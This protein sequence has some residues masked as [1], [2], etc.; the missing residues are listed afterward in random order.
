MCALLGSS[1]RT[2]AGENWTAEVSLQSPPLLKFQHPL[3]KLSVERV[4]LPSQ[5]IDIDEKKD[6]SLAFARGSVKF[7]N[8]VDITDRKNVVV[9]YQSSHGEKTNTMHN[10]LAS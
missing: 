9:R 2:A 10:L 3:L 8:L 6:C 1:R 5:I 4:F 7:G